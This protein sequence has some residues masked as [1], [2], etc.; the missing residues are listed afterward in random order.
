MKGIRRHNCGS[1]HH[2]KK[3]KG[4]SFMTSWLKPLTLNKQNKIHVQ[5]SSICHFAQ[6]CEMYSIIF[7]SSSAYLVM[8]SFSYM[9]FSVLLFP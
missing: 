8:I 9:V 3:K 4:E 7:L 5:L 6:K 2:Y 1:N